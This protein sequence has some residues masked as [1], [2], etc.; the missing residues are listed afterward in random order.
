MLSGMVLATAIHD[1]IPSCLDFTEA[2]LGCRGPPVCISAELGPYL[3]S[4]LLLSY[5][6]HNGKVLRN[7]SFRDSDFSIV[8]SNPNE[9]YYK[10]RK[11]IIFILLS[12]T[13]VMVILKMMCY[14]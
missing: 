1:T 6:K 5:A 4:W 8:H 2:L 14:Y 11:S 13:M 3:C 12:V 10:R 9:G 7:W